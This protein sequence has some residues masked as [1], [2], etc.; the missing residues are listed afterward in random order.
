[1]GCS[2]ASRPAGPQG[3]CFSVERFRRRIS[4]NCIMISSEHPVR[5]M[6]Y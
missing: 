4:V 2:Y 3:Y 1:M 6:S 5:A